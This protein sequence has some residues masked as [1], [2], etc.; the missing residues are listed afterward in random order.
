M[1]YSEITLCVIRSKEPAGT[2]ERNFHLV[3]VLKPVSGS[4]ETDDSAGQL[5][6]AK[7]ILR[8]NFVSNLQSTKRV[9]SFCAGSATQKLLTP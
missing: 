9:K 3:C 1:T 6:E 8:M 7:V 2:W 4:T 5:H